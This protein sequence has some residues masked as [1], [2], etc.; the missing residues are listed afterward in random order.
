MA[1]SGTVTTGTL[2]HSYYYVNWQDAGQS[3]ANNAT[4]INW[5]VGIYAGASSN[6]DYWGNNAMRIDYVSINGGWVQGST[7]YSNIRGPGSF[8]LN[9]GSTTVGHNSDGTKTFNVSLSGWLYS[10]GTTTGSNDFTLN[11]IPRYLKDI[12]NTIDST[13]LN[14]FKIKWTCSP[15][16][17]W[18]QYSLNSGSWADANDNVAADNCSGSYTI[19]G[20]A[21]GTQ[22]SIRTRLRRSDSGLWSE[23]STLYPTTKAISA[24]NG[25]T[26]ATLPAPGNSLTITYN[27]SNPSG[28]STTVFL[29][30][31]KGNVSTYTAAKTTGITSGGSKTLT[32]SSTVVN[33]MY[34]DHTSVTKT[35]G[36]QLRTQTLGDST[37]EP[38]NPYSIEFAMTKANCGPTAIKDMTIQEQNQ[39]IGTLTGTYANSAFKSYTNG[40]GFIMVPGYSDIRVHVPEAPLTTRAGATQNTLTIGDR[41]D[42]NP[43]QVGGCSRTYFATSITSVK[44][45]ATDSRGYDL[46]KTSKT[47]TAKKYTPVTVSTFKIERGDGMSTDAY[48]TFSGAYNP[49][50]FGAV[51]NSVKKVILQIKPKELGWEEAGGYSTTASGNTTGVLSTTAA[52]N[53]DISSMI[54]K[55]TTS[56]ALTCSNLILKTSGTSGNKIQFTT[57]QEYNA[58]IVVIDALTE[59]NKYKSQAVDEFTNVSSGSILMSAVKG[60]GV[61]FGTFYD[62]TVG[63]PLQVDKREVLGATGTATWN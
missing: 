53:F 28:N 31:N 60:E 8:Q 29:D 1:T 54:T 18:T 48:L 50:N 63:G 16:R 11:T 6:W 47:F 45:I 7:T 30:R 43:D 23:A 44:I 58:R 55:N 59:T 34:T 10:Y 62:S 32:L 42:F 13:A 40:E 12:G 36:M 56:G 19:S 51:T 20:R 17:N 27:L 9:S 2:K 25:F 21:P 24:V 52:T 4:T 3:V 38:A 15:A 22:Y 41:T 14:S 39:T 26:A 35:S 57:G 5:Q 33:K 37:Y 61:C 49:I 46:D